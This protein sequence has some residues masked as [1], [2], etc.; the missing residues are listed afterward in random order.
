[1]FIKSAL[2]WLL[3]GTIVIGT[4]ALRQ[5]IL[6]PRLGEQLAHQVGT[7]LVAALVAVIAVIFTR[8][9]RPTPT[10]ALT[11]GLLW[12]A[13]TVAFEVGFFHFGAGVAWSKLLDDYNILRGRLWLLVLLVQLVTPYLAAR[14]VR[15]TL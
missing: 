3:F 14:S 15:Q 4:G 8:A 2:V 9:L 1:M 12:V 10:E 5:A 13:M 11:I 7:G 6:V